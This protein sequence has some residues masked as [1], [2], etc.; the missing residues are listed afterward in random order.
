M[1]KTVFTDPGAIVG[2]AADGRDVRYV[3]ALLV[4]LLLGALLSP[5]IAA[6]AIPELLLNVLSATSTQASIHFHYTATIIPALV[7]ASV[8]GT[9]RLRPP[10]VRRVAPAALVVATLLGGVVLGPLPLWRHIPLGSDLATREHVVGAH[11]RVAA[12]AIAIVPADVPVSA[13]NTLGAH[14][15][16]RR[17]VFSFP[18]LREA[19]WVVVD[20]QRPSYLDRAVAPEQ[21]AEALER[22]RASGAFRVRFDR[23]GL[24]VLERTRAAPV[25]RP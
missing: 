18:V 21:F 6:L 22:L 8:T 1:V 13:T 5:G 12:E 19:T 3:V 7:A 23:D 4:P 16:E 9:A 15:S 25:D 20:R 17:R 14:L 11:A 10:A 2:A 24:L